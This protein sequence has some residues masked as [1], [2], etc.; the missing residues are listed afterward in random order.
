MTRPN[1]LKTLKTPSATD[2]DLLDIPPYLR[3]QAPEPVSARPIKAQ[4]P[5][6]RLVVPKPK[7]KH[8]ATQAQVKALVALG[9]K[10]TTAKLTRRD[11]AAERI[12][13]RVGPPPLKGD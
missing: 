1:P 5:G 7:P 4:H 11:L 13:W 10:P 12:R 3:R 8:Y 6:A 2:N 9:W